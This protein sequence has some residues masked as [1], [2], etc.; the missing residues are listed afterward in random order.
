MP[1]VPLNVKKLTG[2]VG[3]R[4]AN[5]YDDVIAVQQLLNIAGAG[6]KEDGDCGRATISAIEDYQRNWARRPDGRVDPGGSAGRQVA[7][8]QGNAEEQ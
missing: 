2:S 7:G 5:G 4:A 6:V 8:Q 1:S 3:R